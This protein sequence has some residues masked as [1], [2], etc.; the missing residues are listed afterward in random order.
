MKRKTLLFGLIVAAF[1]GGAHI[2][3][4]QQ[5]KANYQNNLIEIGPDNIGGRVRAIVVDEADPKHT[6]LFAGGVAGG[7]FKRTGSNPWQY[8]PYVNS[9]NQQETLPISCMVQL[10][11]NNILIGT[12]EGLAETHG[13]NFERM[14]PKGHGLYI[15]N[16]QDN[17]F[18]LVPNT[19]PATHPEWSYINRIAVYEHGATYVYVATS[20]GLYRWVI[21]SSS[22]WNTAPK[23]IEAGNFQDVIVV[24]SDNI[25]Y[26][27]APG[28]VIRVGNAT[29][30]DQTVASSVRDITSS[31]S[32]FAK[33]SRI[34][35]AY[36]TDHKAG[37]TYL[38]AVVVNAS[39][40]CDGVYLTTNQQNWLLLNT[41]SVIPFNSRNPGTHN[42]SIAVDPLNCKNIYVGG[43]S[44]WNGE[45]FV[46]NS[47]YQWIRQ[48]Y[49]EKELNTGNYM[50][51]VLPNTS[52]VHSGIH[53]IV[54]TWTLE[55]G[56][57]SWVYYFATDGGIY[58]GTS[59]K[60]GAS[61]YWTYS[62]IN[63]GFNT[64]QFNHVA[65]SPD[66][67]IVGGAV[68][69]SCPFIQ[70]RNAH[71]GSVPT[72]SWYD[73][74][75]NSVLNHT[76]SIIWTGSGADVATSM[77]Q[78]LKPFTR[79]TLFVSADPGN[80]Y[81]LDKL[82][83]M[84]LVGSFARACA[85]YSD[86][87]NT[88]T[89]SSAEAFMGDNNYNTNP[90]PKMDLWETTNNT[91]WN[92]SV[93]FIIDTA[94]TYFHN[95]EE[96]Q[97]HGNTRFVVGDSIIVASKPNFNY[98]FFHKFTK[99]YQIDTVV[100][101]TDNATGR[102]TTRTEYRLNLTVPN[103]VVSRMIVNGR[104]GNERSC[105]FFNL[106][107]NYFRNVWSDLEA[108][109]PNAMHWGILYQADSNNV[110]DDIKFS[111][112]G[113][114]IFAAVSDEA[115][116]D[117][118]IMHFYNFNVIDANDPIVMKNRLKFKRDGIDTT[119]YRP[120]RF[121]TI[122]AANNDF[123]KR[124]ISSIAVDPRDGQ[125]NLIV[126]FAGYGSTEPNMVMIRNASDPSNRSVVNLNVTNSGNG[127]TTADPVHSGIIAIDKNN[128]PVLYAG[129]E[130]GVFTSTSLT[131]PSWQN[132]GDFIGVPVTSIVQQ[133]RS[134]QRQS[135]I[136]R[137]GVNRVQYLFAK[138]K[139]PRAIYF[140]TYGR[141]VFMDTTYVTDHVNEVSD[142]ND[143][144]G[145]ATVD[146]GENYMNIYPNPAIDRATIDLGVVNGGNAV[147][148]VY[149][150]SGKVV[151]TE[152]LGYLN[153]GMHQYS[154]NCGKFNRGLY[155]VNINI[156]KESATSKLI[157]R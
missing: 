153:E 100:H 30:S 79:R 1:V 144:V 130:K 44:V 57:T 66:G 147:I 69:N 142:S 124:K 89:W 103:R 42:V 67:S 58:R 7:L 91:I 39:G 134:L 122:F 156:G 127:M 126:T 27:T 135:Y 114:N 64:V 20:E 19:D 84:R 120:V 72:N 157:V 51:S 38:Y 80:F 75:Q 133:T 68:D 151:F 146:N 37:V 52:F 8:V 35:M 108:N 93:S 131:S 46:E 121:D 92:D 117:N 4:A 23:L 90:I 55:N 112:D 145:I 148:K 65:V 29:A 141:G 13:S 115:T 21:N 98:P 128:N 78:Q 77:F 83:A 125:D 96:T 40:L 104:N 10:P 119:G 152:N 132:F 97:L 56:D 136:A 50:A 88:Q 14:S 105:I 70:S 109:S 123:F 62:S 150:I 82:G 41:E 34:E 26:A 33:A 60:Y 74:D 87:N 49:N 31:L 81:M 63:K 113:K 61:T 17:S 47:Y 94:L 16:R 28:K 2:S 116:G 59:F 6:T 154:I 3:S 137:D 76:G 45:G 53:Q 99:P 18:T 36:R 118:Y 85:D 129:T 138:T 15:F 143:W 95:G 106:T 12:G 25:A 101:Y 32:S 11:D 54:P 43:A 71:N 102:D 48:S 9:K 5:P 86:Y 155:L 24:T 73:D 149:D 140:G 111:R 22:D 107:P 110:V 139:Y